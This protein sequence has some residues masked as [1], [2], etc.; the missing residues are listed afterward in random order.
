MP[1]S[2]PDPDPLEAR[3]RHLARQ[4]R[5]LAERMSRLTHELQHGA[6]VP[7]SA[8][9]PPEPPVWRMEDDA[10]PPRATEPAGKRNL[11]RQ[12]QRDM[13]LFFVVLGLLLVATV[14]FIWLWKTHL[15][16]SEGG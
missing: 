15:H 13:I 9:K 3:R 12:R 11:G 7:P 6:D 14:F 2:R 1:W 4:E 5:L 10:R 8:V 16:I